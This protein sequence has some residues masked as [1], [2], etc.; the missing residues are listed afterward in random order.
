[1]SFI[2]R[3]FF[4]LAL[5]L[6]IPGALF[7]QRAGFQGG[8]HAAAP[9][10]RGFGFSAGHAFSHPVGAA[11]FGVTPPAAPGYTGIRP[12]ALRS[13]G[14]GRRDF[15]RVPYGYFFA[16]Y[17]YP[18][19]GYAD[20]AFADYGYGADPGYG[21]NAPADPNAQGAMMAENMLGD[22]INRLSAEVEQLKYGQPPQPMAPV[23]AAQQDSQ[24]PQTPVT[25]VLRNGQ[26]LKVQNYA[27]MD[28]TFWDFSS[29][30]ARKIP[31]S[32]ID[33]AA[34]AKA[35]MASGG[36]FPQLDPTMHDGQ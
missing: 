21:Y 22:Q 6:V 9:A 16:P 27:V 34:S 18:Y 7:A 31:I 5:S 24:P 4:V 30:P 1:M 3:T 10:A 28:Q 12:G 17:Y 36:D 35:T 26:Q 23:P 20:S 8:G 25:L 32:N 2:T 33:V 29:Q 13:N 15:R 19:L 14:F 11:P